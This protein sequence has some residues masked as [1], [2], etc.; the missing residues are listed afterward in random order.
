MFILVTLTT[1]FIALLLLWLLG[2]FY[3]NDFSVPTRSLTE[4]AKP[5]KKF[6][7]ILVIFPHADDEALTAGGTLS[8]LSRQGKKVTWIV[9]TQGEKGNEG[10]HYDEKL[11][12]IR[13]K[14]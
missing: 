4:L 12:S 3:A 11:K 5:P 8:Q 1:I 13:T 10:A 2:F 14:E 7:K 6:N 9:L